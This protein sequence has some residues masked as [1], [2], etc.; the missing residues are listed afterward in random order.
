[1]CPPVLTYVLTL[2][3]TLTL[4]YLQLL[5]V[6]LQQLLGRRTRARLTARDLDLF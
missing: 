5:D 2:T 3:L 1:M 6:R 4:T